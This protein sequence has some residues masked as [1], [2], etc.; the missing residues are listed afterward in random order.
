MC[1]SNCYLLNQNTTRN[2]TITQN[3]GGLYKT[4]VNLVFKSNEKVKL[5]EGRKKK[6]TRVM[7]SK[8]FCHVRYSL[9]LRSKF[10]DLMSCM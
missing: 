2:T 3:K 9:K 7:D 4:Y 1:Y 6:Q 10:R 8:V 5:K